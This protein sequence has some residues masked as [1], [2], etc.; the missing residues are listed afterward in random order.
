MTVDN[1]AAAEQSLVQC[2][3]HLG[4]GL[5]PVPGPN[6]LQRDKGV[7]NDPMHVLK[8]IGDVVSS[9]PGLHDP[10]GICLPSRT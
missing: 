7:R 6:G 4:E 3:P 1:V 2:M 5:L 8:R 9:T 10:K